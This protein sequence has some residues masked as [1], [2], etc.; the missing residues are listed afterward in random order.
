MRRPNSKNSSRPKLINSVDRK[1]MKYALHGKGN[2]NLLQDNTFN[3]NSTEFKRVVQI[4]AANVATK[5]KLNRYKVILKNNKC[6]NWGNRVKNLDHIL[7]TCLS[8]S[9]S[10]I[11]FQVSTVEDESVYAHF[12]V[13]GQKI[14]FLLDLGSNVNILPSQYVT[15]RKLEENT[16]PIQVF[17]CKE[18]NTIDSIYLSM[19]CQCK[20][21]DKTIR[22]YRGR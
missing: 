6:K 7:Q 16:G 8:S 2:H 11:S 10:S 3:M 4:M 17:G 20:S 1:G 12:Y 5:S 22:D 15:G 14:K 19:S 13:D 18:I 9:A 21:R